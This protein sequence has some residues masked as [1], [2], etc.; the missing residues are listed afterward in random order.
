MKSLHARVAACAGS[1]PAGDDIAGRCPPDAPGPGPDELAFHRGVQA[2]LVLPGLKRW[3]TTTFRL[4]TTYSLVFSL[5]IAVLLGVIVCEVSSSMEQRTD[6]LLYWEAHYF[7]RLDEQDLVSSLDRRVEQEHRH[8]TFYG[9]FAAQGKRLAGDLTALPAHLPADGTGHAL[10]APLPVTEAI[11]PPPARVLAVALSGGRTLVVARDISELAEIRDVIGNALVWGGLLALLT[12]VAGGLALSMRQLRRIRETQQVI[13]KIVNG[14]LNERLPIGG[15]DELDMLSHLVNHMLDRIARLMA[16]VKG[17][18]DGVAHDLRTPLG[19]VLKTLTRAR[20][21]A[22]DLGDAEM[23]GPLDYAGG[24]TEALLERFRAMLRISEIES[25]PG[26]ARTF[27][28]PVGRKRSHEHRIAAGRLRSRTCH[29]ATSHPRSHAHAGAA[30][31]G[32]LL[33]DKPSSPCVF[34]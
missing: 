33:S 20:T 32:T 10:D 5:C 16:E 31:H 12:G 25:I 26:P 27:A 3:H 4:F 1:P 11:E 28:S 17:A 21:R 8:S 9:L 7:T 22:H 24:E 15:R 34:C 23:A 30:G 2:Q 14:N 6:R 29:V 13:E 19:H 18:C